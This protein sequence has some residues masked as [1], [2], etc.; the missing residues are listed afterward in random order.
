MAQMSKK[1]TYL[2]IAFWLTIASILGKLLGFLKDILI[3]YYYGSSALTDAIFLALSIP[4]IV[5]GVFT[6]STDSVIIPQYNRIDAKN[7]RLDADRKRL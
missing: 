7:G 2:S 5:L 3:S 6:A 4:M 1:S